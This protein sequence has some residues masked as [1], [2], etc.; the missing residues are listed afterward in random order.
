MVDGGEVSA[1]LSYRA[2]TGEASGKARIIPGK[3]PYIHTGD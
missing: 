2:K 3:V 1:M